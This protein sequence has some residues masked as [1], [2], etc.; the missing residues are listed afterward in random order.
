VGQQVT[1]DATTVQLQIDANAG[2]PRATT[3]RIADRLYLVTQ[4]GP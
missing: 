3:I 4:I 2:S 1:I